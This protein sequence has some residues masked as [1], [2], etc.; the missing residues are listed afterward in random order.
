MNTWNRRRLEGI[1]EIILDEEE[2]RLTQEVDS[3]EAAE[4]K[5]RSNFYIEKGGEVWGHIKKEI[6]GLTQME[7]ISFFL[8][9]L[10][11]VE[12][13]PEEEKCI[14]FTGESPRELELKE[15]KITKRRKELWEK[16]QRAAMKGSQQEY[17]CGHCNSKVNPESC[18][19]SPSGYIYCKEYCFTLY[20][21]D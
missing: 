18:Y 15:R 17:F 12:D 16:N 9:Y 8:G 1:L 7:K 21:S 14:E 4:F 3:T 6:G 19:F 13:Y 11:G 2:Y 10:K 5:A 20:T